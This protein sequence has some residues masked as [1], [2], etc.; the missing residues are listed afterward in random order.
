MLA[1]GYWEHMYMCVVDTHFV[2]RGNSV[3][4]LQVTRNNNSMGVHWEHY[5]HV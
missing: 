2:R 3:G 5:V 4:E 1:W